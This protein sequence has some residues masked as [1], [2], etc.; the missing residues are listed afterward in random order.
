MIQKKPVGKP[1]KKA[2]K[3][4]GA[5]PAPR[6]DKD[7]GE[8]AVIAKIAAMPAPYNAMGERLHAL[9]LRSAPALQPTLHYGMPWYAKDGKRVCFFRADKYMTFG[10]TEDANLTVEEGAPHQLLESAWYFAALDDA[11]EAKLSAIVRKAAS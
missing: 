10:L 6:A 5:R 11:T 7:H 8:A 2:A 9:I 3:K 4:A 1:A